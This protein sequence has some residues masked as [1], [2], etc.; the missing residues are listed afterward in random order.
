MIRESAPP[1]SVGGANICGRGKHLWEGHPCPDTVKIICI[2]GRGK[3]LWEGHPCPDASCGRDKHLWEG[4]PCPDA[5]CGRDKHLWEGHPCPDSSV[6]TVHHLW[7]G[8]TPVG[9]ASLPRCFRAKT[10]NRDRLALQRSAMSI[11]SR[12]TKSSRSR[13]AQCPYN[14][15]N[16]RNTNGR[17]IH[18]TLHTHGLF[19]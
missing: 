9:R 10:R 15:L 14:N 17:Y 1:A 19:R 13:G 8:Q 18:P 12:M 2:C 11:D 4:H 5:S 6:R 16:W 3:H 7:E